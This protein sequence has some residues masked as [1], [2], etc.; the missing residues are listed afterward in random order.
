MIGKL[1]ASASLKTIRKAA[2]S[3]STIIISAALF[4]E[5]TEMIP[6]VILDHCIFERAILDLRPRAIY[7]VERE[8]EAEGEIHERF[9]SELGVDEDEI[10]DEPASVLIF[11][12]VQRFL[13]SWQKHDGTMYSCSA[14]FMLDGVLHCW[15]E[16]E[17]WYKIFDSEL[18]EL[19]EELSASEDGRRHKLASDKRAK[20]SERANVLAEH[21]LFNAPKATKAKRA[22]LAAQLFPESNDLDI[23]VIV[24]EAESI[25]WYQTHAGEGH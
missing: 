10:L 1:E 19:A 13:K 12:A 9:A 22:Y 15:I 18:D 24:E 6:L 23:S 3:V 21:A 14:R 8:F 5:K 7:L 16:M 2:E 17:E 25:F 11:P 4:V 20:L